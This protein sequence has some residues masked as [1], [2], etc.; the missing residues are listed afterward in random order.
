[1]RTVLTTL[2]LAVSALLETV[3]AKEVSKKKFRL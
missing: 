2:R 1:M 3:A